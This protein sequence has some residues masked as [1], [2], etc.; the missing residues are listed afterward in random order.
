MSQRNL[1]IAGETFAA[2]ARRFDRR[3]PAWLLQRANKYRSGL[4]AITRKG[5]YSWRYARFILAFCVISN[6]AAVAQKPPEQHGPD[7][8]KLEIYAGTWLQQPKGSI[9]G[10]NNNLNIDL[11]RDLNFERQYN[12]LGIIN[13]GFARK[14][15][16]IFETNP[17]EAERTVTLPRT[18]ALRNDTFQAG[19]T[20]HAEIKTFHFYPQYQYNFIQRRRGHVGLN[21][22]VDLFDIYTEISSHAS[23]NGPS[24]TQTPSQ[25]DLASLFAGLPTGG[26]EGR[27]FIFR[28][29]DFNGHARGM[30]F[31]GY[32]R[33][34]ETRLNGGLHFGR[35]F[36]LQG[37][38]QFLRETEI[39]NEAKNVNR[40]GLGLKY[41]GPLYGL[42]LRW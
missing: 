40:F 24:G 38:Y 27:I 32:G 37:G 15:H 26:F 17:S 22:G 25:K 13:W 19:S 35:H 11:Q 31:F 8:S 10:G 3:L 34:L 41:F 2:G 39:H 14:H 4:L 36:G 16:L 5:F 1:A 29:L 33:Y 9:H 6:I 42:T 12:F 18:I 30:Y 20:A 21:F 28:W 23:P 7:E